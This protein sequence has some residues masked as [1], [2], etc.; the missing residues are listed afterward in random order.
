MA[1]WSRKQGAVVLALALAAHG[2][3]SLVIDTSDIDEGCS[4]GYKLCHGRCVLKTDPAFGCETGICSPCL[5]PNAIPVCKAAPGAHPDVQ[6]LTCAVKECTLGF[7]CGDCSA[8]AFSD[9]L[10]CGYCNHVCGTGELCANGTC[11]TPR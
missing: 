6:E 5:L 3:C 9:E 8:H 10:N 7:T 11:T 4:D 1:K 2:G